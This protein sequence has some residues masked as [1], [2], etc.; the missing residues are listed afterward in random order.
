MSNL[1]KDYKVGPDASCNEN[2][3]NVFSNPAP[4]FLIPIIIKCNKL[5]IIEA[6]TFLDSNTLTCFMDKELVQQ[7]KFALMEK[8]HFN[9]N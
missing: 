7:Y 6:Q 1:S 2:G 3:P 9:V 5:V 8:K 4:C